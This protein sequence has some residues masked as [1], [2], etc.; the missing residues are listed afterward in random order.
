MDTLSLSQ[1]QH[2]IAPKAA[3]EQI[4]RLTK[5][6]GIKEIKDAEGVLNEQFTRLLK[7]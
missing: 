6:G 1:V 5:I 3:E 7:G 4:N 2:D